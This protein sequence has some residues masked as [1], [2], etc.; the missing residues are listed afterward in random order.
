MIFMASCSPKSRRIGSLLVAL[1]VVQPALAIDINKTT[2]TITKADVRATAEWQEY[3][4]KR[5][6]IKQLKESAETFKEGHIGRKTLMEAYEKKRK[7]FRQTPLAKKARRLR[8]AVGRKVTCYGGNC[9]P[10]VFKQN[11]LSRVMKKATNS[12]LHCI[13][14]APCTT[15]KPT[16]RE[17]A[18]TG[19]TASSSR[20][21]SDTGRQQ[22]GSGTTYGDVI[23]TPPADPGTFDDP[24]MG[25]LGTTR[26]APG[27]RYPGEHYR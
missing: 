14:T 26:C 6:E 24:C 15:R 23:A 4:E 2:A 5:K 8:K 20:P 12:G 10:G 1:F 19:Y 17:L 9:R 27:E 22:R 11:A 13:D 18:A 7:A 25:L 21:S 16:D 3:L